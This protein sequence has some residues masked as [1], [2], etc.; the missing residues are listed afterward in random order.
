MEPACVPLV[1]NDRPRANFPI[2]DYL[3]DMFDRSKSTASLEA[4]RTQRLVPKRNSRR[5][6]TTATQHRLHRVDGS[7]WRPL[8]PSR[9]SR[10]QR[11]QKH[12]SDFESD[13]PSRR[14]TRSFLD[15]RRRQSQRLAFVPE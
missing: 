13:R 8:A 7:N 5:G 9:A 3:P 6:I 12:Q 4:Q 10:T 11:S 15:S 14:K 2:E 1:R